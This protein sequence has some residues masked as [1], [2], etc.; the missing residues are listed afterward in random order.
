MKS[1]TQSTE[2]T[3]VRVLLQRRSVSLLMLSLPLRDVFQCCVVIHQL[4]VRASAKS[5]SVGHKASDSI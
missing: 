4:S 3:C 1:G 5:L 2:S